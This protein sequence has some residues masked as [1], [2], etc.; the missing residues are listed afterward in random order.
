MLISYLILSYNIIQLTPLFFKTKTKSRLSSRSAE[1]N[2]Q[3]AKERIAKRL[4]L[5]KAQ[6]KGSTV[7]DVRPKPGP[8]SSKGGSSK[9]RSHSLFG[10]RDQLMDFSEK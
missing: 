2:I 1:S 10:V 7:P 8:S 4:G 5:V 6:N 9:E 3:S